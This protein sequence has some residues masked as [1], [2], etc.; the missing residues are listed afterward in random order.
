MEENRKLYKI[1]NLKQDES[2]RL[3]EPIFE[4]HKTIPIQMDPP[5]A[6]ADCCSLLIEDTFEGSKTEMCK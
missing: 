6:H 3:K 5:E 2:E 1:H 4:S